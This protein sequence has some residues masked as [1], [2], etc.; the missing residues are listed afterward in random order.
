L[1]LEN[2]ALE[3]SGSFEMI[4]NDAQDY[5]KDTDFN[6]GKFLYEKCYRM[7]LA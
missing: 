1:F 4:N 2:T 7:L 6:E 5:R 3:S